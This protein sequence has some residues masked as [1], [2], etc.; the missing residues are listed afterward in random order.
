MKPGPKKTAALKAL[1]M[2]KK[3][4]TLTL[5]FKKKLRAIYKQN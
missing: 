5:N 2:S 3:I 4:M 1:A